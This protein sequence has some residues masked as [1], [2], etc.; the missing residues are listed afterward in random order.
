V[1][2]YL[3][4]PSESSLA[5]I[6]KDKA[7]ISTLPED[8][9]AD[10]LVYTKQGLLGIQRKEIPHDFLSSLDDGRLVRSLEL[11]SKECKF[12]LLLLEGKFRYFPDGHLFITRKVMSRF[13]RRQVRGVLFDVRYIRDV[14]FD[15]TEDVEDTAYYINW[16]ADW[17]SK[18]QHLGLFRR[19]SARGDW[20]IPSTRE[21]HRWL[22]QSFR[23]IGPTTA[24]K[25]LQYFE[26]IPLRWTCSVGELSKVSGLSKAKAAELYSILNGPVAEGGDQQTQ[27]NFEDLRSRLRR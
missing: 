26:G 2:T 11:L 22:L 1:P 23:G 17:M 20:Y 3:L 6:F 27:G 24:D 9:G 7:V 8:K 25:I 14:E 15:F 21:I 16:L 5:K 19:P 10:I 12:S 18:E 13:T 4:S